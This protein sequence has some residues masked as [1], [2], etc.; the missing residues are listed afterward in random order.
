V[1]PVLQLLDSPT[2]VLE[3]CRHG[4]RIADSKLAYLKVLI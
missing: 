3:C 1:M 2:Q 4:V